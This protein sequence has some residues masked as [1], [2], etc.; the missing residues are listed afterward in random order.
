MAAPSVVPA[1][2]IEQT[3]KAIEEV[4]SALWKADFVLQNYEQ[5][6]ALYPHL[7]KIIGLLMGSAAST[8]IDSIRQLRDFVSKL[9]NTRIGRIDDTYAERWILKCL[10]NHLDRAKGV[11][12][13][14]ATDYP[15]SPEHLVA[16][17]ALGGDT[18]IM[19]RSTYQKPSGRY[20]E[21]G[22]LWNEV[23][24]VRNGWLALRVVDIRLENNNL[25]PNYPVHP[26]EQFPPDWTGTYS[27]YGLELCQVLANSPQHRDAMRNAD[28]IAILVSFLALF[29]E[30]P[31]IDSSSGYAR[32]ARD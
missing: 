7:T 25:P 22:R 27:V 32:D 20:V 14:L 17:T 28:N 6:A 29:W 8:N 16:E 13:R 3:R 9:K 1:E 23:N 10:Q 18:I 30:H 12:V 21:W 5:C 2:D 26:P 24:I 4:E 31:E 19:S 11:S 15:K